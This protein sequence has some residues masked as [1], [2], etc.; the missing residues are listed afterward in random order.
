MTKEVH[1]GLNRK[2]RMVTQGDRRAPNRSML[3]AVGFT[4]EDFDKPIILVLL[5]AKAILP[6]AT[7]DWENF[8]KSP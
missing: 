8:P 4:D 3:R 1:P 7:L 2:S 5:M 6:R